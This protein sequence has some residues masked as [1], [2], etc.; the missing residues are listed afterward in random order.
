MANIIPKHGGLSSREQFI[1][2]FRS[3]AASKA[4]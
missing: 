2:L 4:A 1:N 3:R